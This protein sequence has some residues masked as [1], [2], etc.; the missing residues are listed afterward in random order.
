MSLDVYL[1]MR[2]V[3][4]IEPHRAIFIREDGTTKEITRDEWDKRFPDREPVEVDL[5]GDDDCVFDYNITHNLNSMAEEVGIYQALWRPDEIG[6]T[7]AKQL[8]PL[9]RDGLEKLKADPERCKKFN[10]ENGW[11]NYEGLLDVVQKYLK[12]CEEYPEAEIEVSR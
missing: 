1:K 10:P 5:V 7:K 6:V 12:A 11:G 3:Q 8:I 2:G 9:L 4:N